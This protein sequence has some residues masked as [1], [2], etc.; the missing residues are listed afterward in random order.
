[1]T[2]AH[3]LTM[4]A[5]APL[6]RHVAV[7][8]IAETAVFMLLIGLISALG[9]IVQRQGNDTREPDWA[10]PAFQSIRRLGVGH[11][12]GLVLMIQM[13]S[14][15]AGE[16]FEQHAAGVSLTGLTALFG[17]TLAAAPFIHLGIGITAGM[18]LWFGAREIC[19]HASVVAGIIRAIVEWLSRER[20]LVPHRVVRAS[21]AMVSAPHREPLAYFLANRPPPISV[22]TK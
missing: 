7:A 9:K 11:T 12:V 19:G 21:G 18:L 1:M 22:H 20:S 15:A 3:E 8:P 10:L 14:L 13:L 5:P 16:S 4:V 6:Y 17:T 2:L